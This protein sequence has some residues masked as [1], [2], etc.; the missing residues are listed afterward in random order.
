MNISVFSDLINGNLFQKI[1]RASNYKRLSLINPGFRF[2]A[3]YW[4]IYFPG[5]IPHI[6]SESFQSRF[7]A[8]SSRA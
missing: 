2:F 3:F 8:S 6:C 5:S 4:E 1:P 7:A